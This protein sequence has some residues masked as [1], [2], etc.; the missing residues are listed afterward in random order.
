MRGLLPR[1]D[2]LQKPLFT[3]T[4][5][6]IL[7]MSGNTA[8]NTAD[9]DT[10]CFHVCIRPQRSHGPN[11]ADESEE[12]KQEEE[13]A[14]QG[15][16]EEDEGDEEEEEE[17]DVNVKTKRMTMGRTKMNKRLTKGMR[18]RRMRMTKRRRG[19]G[20]LLTWKWKMPT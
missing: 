18:R 2:I 7:V 20:P 9:P 10:S 16:E 4:C 6:A 13:E 3:T 14:D 5:E 1:V 15:D 8:E 12:I 11:T 19:R 17:E